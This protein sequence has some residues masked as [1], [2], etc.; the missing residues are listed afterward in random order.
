[1]EIK[2]SEQKIRVGLRQTQPD[3]FD[4]FK[5]KKVN[6]IITVKIISSDSKGLVV[7]P[8]D[9]EMDFIIKKNQ[10]AI[11]SAD[12]RPSRFTGGERIDC[13]ISDLDINKRKVALSIKLLEELEK[14]EAL[15][16]YGAEDSGKNLPFSSLSSKLNKKNKK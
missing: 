1:M 12:A 4:W 11:N 9:C 13:A 14:K 7:R 8:Q 2:T 5:D 3:P 6:Q 16:K 10:I 15:E